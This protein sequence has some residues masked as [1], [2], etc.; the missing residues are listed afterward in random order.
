[1]KIPVGNSA[2][3]DLTPS[4][5]Y[6]K[7]RQPWT[8][9]VAKDGT[10]SVSGEAVVSNGNVWLTLGIQKVGIQSNQAS[11]KFQLS[12]VEEEL[13]QPV[14]SEQTLT[15]ANSPVT[16]SGLKRGVTYTIKV[17]SVPEDYI[18]PADISFVSFVTSHSSP[19]PSTAVILLVSE[20]GRKLV[21]SVVK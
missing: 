3:I 20:E 13:T 9:T 4:T 5:G 7:P 1:M 16:I 10:L 12:Y 11:T 14:G 21:P 19:V 17:T 2:D 18:F 15:A 6:V 8:V